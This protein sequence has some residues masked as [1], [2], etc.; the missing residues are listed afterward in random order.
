[1]TL[2]LNI[3]NASTSKDNDILLED[4]RRIN[5]KRLFKLIIKV[6]K[7]IDTNMDII[8]YF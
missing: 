8:Y 2:E 7:Q 5:I 4:N 3:A 6:I 1:M